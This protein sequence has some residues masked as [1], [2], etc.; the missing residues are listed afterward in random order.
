MSLWSRLRWPPSLPAAAGHGRKGRGGSGRQRAVAVA[1]GAL[2][3]AAKPVTAPMYPGTLHSLILAS[4]STIGH[5][6]T[7][8]RSAG[9]PATGETKYLGAP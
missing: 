9:L 4:V 7:R 8:P 6:E 1:D 2:Q 3:A 5:K